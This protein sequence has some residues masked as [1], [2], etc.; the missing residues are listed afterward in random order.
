M[1]PQVLIASQ[2]GRQVVIGL[3]GLT[4]YP[5]PKYILAKIAVLLHKRGFHLG[6]GEG[7]LW[8]LGCRVLGFRSLG[9]R[10]VRGLYVNCAQGY[11][12]CVEGAVQDDLRAEEDPCRSG[13]RRYCTWLGLCAFSRLDLQHMGGVA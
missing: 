5:Y 1:L 11:A 6:L 3:G 12:H 7:R 8:R 9:F 2:V 13:S 10:P 4:G